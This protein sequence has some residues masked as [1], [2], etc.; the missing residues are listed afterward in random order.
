MQLGD[1]YRHN[2]DMSNPMAS[3]DAQKSDNKLAAMETSSPN[4]D[5]RSGGGGFTDTVGQCA[6]M[7][8]RAFYHFLEGNIVY[9]DPVQSF[10]DEPSQKILTYKPE[11]IRSFLLP[12]FQHDL[13]ACYNIGIWIKHIAIVLYAIILAL[14][15]AYEYYP[16]GK[17]G[18]GPACAGTNNRNMCSL[19]TTLA[20]AKLEFRFLIA[21]I[22]AGFVANSVAN[23]N[24]RR[25]IYASLCGN[26]RNCLCTVN[27][28]I[29]KKN[30]PRNARTNMSRWV[31]LVYELSVLKARGHMDSQEGRDHLERL[32]LLL[33]GEWECMCPHDRH[34]SVVFWINTMIVGYQ[35]EGILISEHSQ[36]ALID[37]TSLRGYANDLM[38]SINIDEPISYSALTGLLVKTNVFIFSTWK[39][40]EWS[41]WIKSFGPGIL[42]EDQSRMMIDIF[43]LLAWNVSYTAL[44]DLGYMLNNP[45]GNRRIDLPHET[46]G[47]GLRNFANALTREGH[48]L[49]PAFK[50]Q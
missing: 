36:K 49:P 38:S 17:M 19:E 24:Q 1:I 5:S 16:D 45:F 33:P 32:N 37:I 10:Y 15:L 34:T 8:Q 39:A 41:A 18:D 9:G 42:F 11:G 30:D 25:T 50:D 6:Q 27:S 2:D 40:V 44:Y 35:R 21:F 22:L 26:V 23:W 29:S 12:F 13:S 3:H 14:I 43:V 46:I 4:L 47:A 48:K 31:L 7:G 20:E 28:I